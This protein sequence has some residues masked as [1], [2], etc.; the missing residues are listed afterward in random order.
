MSMSVTQILSRNPS[1]AQ[2][3]FGAEPLTL[4]QAKSTKLELQR[5]KALQATKVALVYG[6]QKA[7]AAEVHTLSRAALYTGW[8]ALLLN[9][10]S[11]HKQSLGTSHIPTSAVESIITIFAFI[12]YIVLD[13]RASHLDTLAERSKARI[14]ALTQDE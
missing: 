3:R 2:S 8:L 7:S 4:E 9:L 12:S 6:D 1:H 14:S 10:L 11:S 5:I 13:F